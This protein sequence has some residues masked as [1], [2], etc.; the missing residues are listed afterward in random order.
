MGSDLR[1]FERSG[2][3]RRAL[4]GK[5]VSVEGSEKGEAI[6]GALNPIL[7]SGSGFRV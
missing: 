3:H 1:F 7:P 5:R 6:S 4:G 2:V